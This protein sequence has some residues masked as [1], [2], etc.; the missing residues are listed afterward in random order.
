MCPRTVSR[1]ALLRTGA[2][3]SGLGLLHAL[4]GCQALGGDGASG[5]ADATR[6]DA[7]PVGADAVVGLDVAALLADSPI[8]EGI[9]RFLTEGPGPQTVEAALDRAESEGGLD[10]RGVRELLGFGTFR[11]PSPNGA[12][13]WTDW[14]RSELFDALETRA[15]GAGETTYGDRPVLTGG[16][17]R[18]GAVG[19]LEDGVFAV[20]EQATVE[21]TIDRWREEADPLGGEVREAYVSAGSGHAR[22]GFDVPTEEIPAET[23]GPFD[24]SPLEELTYGYGSLTTDGRLTVSLRATGEG[25]AGDAASIIESGLA[26]AREEVRTAPES[27][28]R[29][30]LQQVLAGT[31]VDQQGRVVTVD[32]ENGIEGLVVVSGTVGTSLLLGDGEGLGRPQ[33]VTP[34]AAFSFD[35]VPETRQL[36]IVHQAGNSIPA[37]ELYVRGEGVPTGSW[38]DLGGPTSGEAD[39]TPAVTAGDRLS[40]PNVEPDYEVRVVWEPDDGDASAVLARGDGPGE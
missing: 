20:G 39:G 7:A 28:R 19:V 22:F 12:V 38:D 2:T 36:E 18:D 13:L 5:A 3:V 9:D 23:G 32:T 15:G 34:Q 33:Q 31:A 27:E 16:A 21:A 8:R 17:G 14:S 26:L 4:A 29:E 1:R 30:R 35:F 11:E 37:A 25:A 10:P 40:L 6:I 24:A